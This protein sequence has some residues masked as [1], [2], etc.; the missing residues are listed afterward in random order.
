MYDGR[1]AQSTQVN[2]RY[3]KL[4]K[5]RKENA[6]A[7]YNGLVKAQQMDDALASKLRSDKLNADKLEETKRVDAENK[8]AK[9]RAFE[10]Q[11][12]QDAKKAEREAEKAKTAGERWQSTFNQNERRIKATAAKNKTANTSATQ[13]QTKFALG[14]GKELAIDDN[15]WAGSWQQAYDMMLPEFKGQRGIPKSSSSVAE[16]ENWVKQHW[17]KSPAATKFMYELAKESLPESETIANTSDEEIEDWFPSDEE[18]RR[19]QQRSRPTISSF[20]K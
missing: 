6:T 4:I 5:D 7:Y 11:K 15:V 13:K 17:R 20:L 1:K 18:K 19:A 14:N 8:K 2:S 12:E 16:K 10:Y 9:D 3:D